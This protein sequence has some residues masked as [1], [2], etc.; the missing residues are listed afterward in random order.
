MAILRVL[1]FWPDA[2][3]GPPAAG[4]GLAIPPGVNVLALGLKE[5]LDDPPA[6]PFAAPPEGLDE[7]LPCPPG[8]LRGAAVTPLP[9]PFP[10]TPDDETVP[11]VLISARAISK[12]RFV[13]GADL[14]AALFALPPAQEEAALPIDAGSR[15]S[16]LILFISDTE[17]EARVG[18]RG[19]GAAA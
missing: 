14:A 5:N 13:R 12:S 8:G 19:A 7:P 17:A 3:A 18:G 6:P 16:A 11:L 10:P 1:P 2:P 9:L 15:L 4:G